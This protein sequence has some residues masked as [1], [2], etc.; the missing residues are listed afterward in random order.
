MWWS[1]SE[2]FS[3]DE[4]DRTIAK[5]AARQDE[6]DCDVFK[7][8]RIGMEFLYMGVKMRVSFHSPKGTH[9]LPPGFPDVSH[10]YCSYV[11]SNGVIRLYSIS[12][13]DL[14]SLDY[15][16]NKEYLEGETDESNTNKQP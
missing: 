14:A 3:V 13:E 15:R 16:L 7:V 8:Y 2:E 9:D 11:D 5:Q 4:C 10:A 6:M 1:K 12:I